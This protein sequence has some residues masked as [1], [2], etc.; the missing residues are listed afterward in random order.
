MPLGV[1]TPPSVSFYGDLVELGA[2]GDARPGQGA[3]PRVPV[4]G[5]E[6]ASAVCHFLLRQVG[7]LLG[8]EHTA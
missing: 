1:L 8:V 4:R 7:A 2:E 5:S 3:V 6:E